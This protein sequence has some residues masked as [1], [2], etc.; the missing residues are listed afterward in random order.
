VFGGTGWC[1]T[2]DSGWA[3]S[4]R[5]LDRDAHAA[6]VRELARLHAASAAASRCETCALVI[7]V[8]GRCPYCKIRYA[9]GEPVLD[10][11]G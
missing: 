11:G 10:D 5:F 3:G 1:T 6:A 9:L 2:C 8:D 7:L 4:V